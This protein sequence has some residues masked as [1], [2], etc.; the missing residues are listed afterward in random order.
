VTSSAI[1]IV[2]PWLGRSGSTAWPSRRHQKRSPSRRFISRSISNGGRRRAA[3]RRCGRSRLVVGLDPDRGAG[4]ARH[5][6][7]IPAEDLLQARVHLDEPASR[8]SAMPIEARSRIAACSSRVRSL[9][10]TSRGVDDHV[11]AP[12]HREARRRDED[13]RAAPRA[14]L[15]RRRHR[16]DAAVLADR[17]AQAIAVAH[18]GPEAE[19]A[20]VL[21][22]RFLAE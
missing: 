2:P 21:A 3:G 7:G 20:G 4:F 10:V 14:L 6:A 18:V 16:V 1:Q 5:R 11:V 22:D 12:V 15:Q 8:V 17:R 19:L 9:S 13:L